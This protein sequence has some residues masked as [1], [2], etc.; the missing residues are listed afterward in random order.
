MTK[1]YQF[2]EFAIGRGLEQ[3]VLEPTRH[4]PDNILDLV[5][6]SDPN[7]LIDLTVSEPFSTSDHSTINLILDISLSRSIKQQN[8]RNFF[9][10]NYSKISAALL[11]TNW[12]DLFDQQTVDKM[13]LTFVHQLNLLIEKHVP[14]RKGSS[15]KYRV[16]FNVHYVKILYLASGFLEISKIWYSYS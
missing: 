9:K 14:V 4:G 8:S 10:A 1:Q 11:G 12:D 16:F 5:L 7:K 15:R 13:W 6:L 2:L 3:C